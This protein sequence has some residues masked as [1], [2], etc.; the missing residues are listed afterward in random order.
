M[1]VLKEQPLSGLCRMLETATVN[2]KLA[3][4]AR[5]N[6]EAELDIRLRAPAGTEGS[7]TEIADIYK[8]KITRKLSRS[9][10]HEAY[11]SLGLPPEQ[12]TFVEYKPTLNLKEM[13]IMERI[14]PE[15]IAACITVKPA[16]TSFK[17]ERIQK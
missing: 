8:I 17:L 3:K 2:E 14:N 5:L 4:E 16:K 11:L 6:I 1:T 7:V 12:A 15:A 13:R 9:L 10:D